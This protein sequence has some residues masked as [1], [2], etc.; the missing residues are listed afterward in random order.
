MR[1]KRKRDTVTDKTLE[2]FWLD[3]ISVFAP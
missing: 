1:T 3:W 2:P